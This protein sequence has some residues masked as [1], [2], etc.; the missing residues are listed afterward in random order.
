MPP[1]LQP[2]VP[3]AATVCVQV[4]AAVWTHLADTAISHDEEVERLEV[5]RV[6]RPNP[7]EA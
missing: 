6:R 5:V 4:S 7:A 2:Y 1:W 3:R